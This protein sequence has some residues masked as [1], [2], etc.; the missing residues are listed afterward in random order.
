MSFPVRYWA[1]VRRLPRRQAQAIALTYLEGL[2]LQEI[3]TVLDVSVPTVGTHLQRARR[4]L[5]AAL[6]VSEE[7]I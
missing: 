2:T 5:A 6:N 4:T 3:A 7:V 1:A